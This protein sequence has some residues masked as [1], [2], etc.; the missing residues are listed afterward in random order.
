MPYI[1]QYARP[2][3]D[4]AI[5]QIPTELTAGE[6][7]YIITRLAH[8]HIDQWGKTYAT[9][10]ETMGVL[11]C[12]AREFYRKVAAPYEDLKC[13]ENGDIERTKENPLIDVN[14]WHQTCP[15]L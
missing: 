6:L 9:L 1:P 12:V 5:D 7:N 8:R 4:R 10:N 3:L 11:D 13:A 14:G 2:A 15:K